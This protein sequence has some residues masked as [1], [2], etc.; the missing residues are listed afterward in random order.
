MIEIPR[1][2]SIETKPA[3][4]DFSWPPASGTP[5]VALVSGANCECIS[6]NESFDVFFGHRRGAARGLVDLIRFV[7]GDDFASLIDGVLRSGKPSSVTSRA[8]RITDIDH[9]YFGVVLMDIV[10]EPMLLADGKTPAVLVKAAATS[11]RP[12]QAEP[13]SPAQRLVTPLDFLSI[14]QDRVA[15]ALE[16]G[17]IGVWEWDLASGKSVW[18]SQMYQLIGAAP[19]AEPA[20]E[21]LMALVHPQD[22]VV[23][24]AK[25][26][27]SLATQT[28]FSDDFRIN[29]ADTGEQR[30]I[31]GRGRVLTNMD[32]Q[33]IAMM[34]VNFDI[35]DEINNQ[36]KLKA[37][38]QR[39]AE[40]LAMLGHELR[41]PLA[42]LAYIARKM[43][44]T[45]ER[46]TQQADAAEVIKRQVAQL[47]RLV[48]D[49]LEVSRIE[50]GKIDLR[51]QRL[52]LSE[53]VEAAV[54]AI[55][56]S[57]KE[58]RQHLKWGVPPG[59]W[60]Q[61]D[62]ARLTQVISNLM[63][64]ASKYTQV[65]GH[66]RLNVT[67][68]S[69]LVCI[70]VHDNGPGIDADLAS[71]LFDPFTQGRATLDRARD[72][73]GI[74]LS[75]VKKLV[76]LHGGKISFSTSNRGTS[77]TVALPLP[78]VLVPSGAPEGSERQ[79]L[80]GKLPSL[81]ILVVEDN[82]DAATLLAGLMRDEGHEVRLAVDG[83][84]ALDMAHAHA[85][86]VILMDVGLPK[87][88]GWTVASLLRAEDRY[89]DVVM[90]AMSGYGQPEDRHRSLQAGFNLHL[91]KPTDLNEVFNFLKLSCRKK[92]MV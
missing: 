84:E 1:L 47:T 29:R 39:R 70:S 86:D 26:A 92:A 63:G 56:P 28:D 34:G 59:T 33:V 73:L 10:C 23:L 7:D 81:R 42:P 90:I 31:A 9:G 49:L 61:G 17:Q 11:V 64:N 37:V 43:E 32:G 44:N 82:L 80:L 54:E 13:A 2:A 30:W 3:E 51:M 76:E 78:M 18:N 36:E 40:F 6:T 21:V 67:P 8:V 57:V 68:D 46:G 88:D 41:N 53:V 87:L 66:I 91:T 72:G 69:D 58:R 24:D 48:E 25:I 71:M 19:S 38:A 74:G 85:F 22:R 55:M 50:L 62:R 14:G 4:F 83:Q 45:A 89:K 12:W 52:P 15:L 77:F 79:A 20:A 60:V 16:V 5:L 35:T 65:G 75:I 27:R